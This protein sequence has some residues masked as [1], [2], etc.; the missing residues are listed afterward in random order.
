V[1]QQQ[2]Q[3]TVAVTSAAAQTSSSDQQLRPAAQ[4]S[5]SKQQ[6]Q[7]RAA[8]GLLQRACNSVLLLLWLSGLNCKLRPLPGHSVHVQKAVQAPSS[9]MPTLSVSTHKG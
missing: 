6:Q 9:I 1:R 2:Q 8:D 5:S 4:S 7:L 3:Q